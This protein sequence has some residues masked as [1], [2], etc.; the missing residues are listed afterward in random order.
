M[1]YRKN[2]DTKRKGSMWKSKEV[3]RSKNKDM[4]RRGEERKRKE[5]DSYSNFEQ[6]REVK[7][8]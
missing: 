4:L 3:F 7:I 6:R 2:R 5:K 8:I 1:V